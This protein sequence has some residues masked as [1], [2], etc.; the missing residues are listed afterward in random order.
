MEGRGLTGEVCAPSYKQG[1]ASGQLGPVRWDAICTGAH[2]TG[3]RLLFSPSSGCCPFVPD[4]ADEL[5]KQ[6]LDREDERKKMGKLI[7]LVKGL[8]GKEFKT[9]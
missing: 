3:S 9:N 6:R 1:E 2:G 8:V 5:P 4:M 7:A